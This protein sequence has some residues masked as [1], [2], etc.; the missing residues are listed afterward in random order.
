MQAGGV[1]DGQINVGGEIGRRF[2]GRGSLR[3]R[4]AQGRN[5]VVGVVR[6]RQLAEERARQAPVKMILP[7]AF[8]IFPSILIILLMPAGIQLTR[9]FAGIGGP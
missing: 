8:L 3:P 7:L 4:P 9:A 6:R 1:V 2:G 5:D